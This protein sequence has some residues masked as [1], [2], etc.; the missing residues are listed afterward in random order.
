MVTVVE[1]EALKV[2]F[3]CSSALAEPVVVSTAAIGPRVTVAVW[4][5]VVEAQAW[6]NLYLVDVSLN[7]GGFGVFWAHQ[8]KSNPW[9]VNQ[10]KSM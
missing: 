4:T 7:S 8:W 1:P 2:S 9:R 10:A 5:E 3:V 6:N